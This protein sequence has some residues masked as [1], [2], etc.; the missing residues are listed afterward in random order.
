MEKLTLPVHD[1]YIRMVLAYIY[2][3]SGSFIMNIQGTKSCVH[4]RDFILSRRKIVHKDVTVVP[5][6]LFDL[7]FTYDRSDAKTK[8][9]ER[10][11]VKQNFVTK[12]TSNSQY[13]SIN[14]KLK[15]NKQSPT[16]RKR[17][18]LLSSSSENE[19]SENS[20]SK[21]PSNKNPNFRS[22]KSSESDTPD[23][24]KTPGPASTAPNP[25]GDLDI[26]SKNETTRSSKP[27]K[28]SSP[29]RKVF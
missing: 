24:P 28:P 9:T 5:L 14:L 8:D 22:S 12:T 26:D 6:F 15:E 18:P 21:P 16:S 7:L 27:K 4:N 2:I 11:K 29:Y 1:N 10:D 17:P 25:W 23:I 3:Q 20:S 13:T 19:D